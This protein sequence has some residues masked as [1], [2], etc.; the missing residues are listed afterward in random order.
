[1]ECCSECS[2]PRVSARDKWRMRDDKFGWLL[3]VGQ[4]LTFLVAGG[5][6]V[7]HSFGFTVFGKTLTLDGFT[8][9]L[10]G[11]MTLA[12]VL[13]QVV[14]IRLTKEGFEIGLQKKGERA[15]QL[16]E[17]ATR[18]RPLPAPDTN[19]VIDAASDPA[20]SLEASRR[21]LAAAVRALATKKAPTSTEASISGLATDLRKASAIDANTEKAVKTLASTI[22]TGK[23]SAAV[24]VSLALD[25]DYATRIVVAAL[26]ELAG[27]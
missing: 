1:M 8:L 7:V 26:M 10:L 4:A 9:A 6:L 16:A 11:F 5:L 20:A 2:I 27:P 15:V 21:S 25:V 3:F 13:P 17:T 14:S 19:A 22:S 12:L 24:P 23:T 18:G